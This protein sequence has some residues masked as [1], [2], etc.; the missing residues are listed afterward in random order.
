MTKAKD[1]RSHSMKEQA[2]LFKT[3]GF[4][5]LSALRSLFAKQDSKPRLTRWIL[6]LQEFDIEIRDKKGVKNLTADHLSQLE[7]P[8]LGKLTRAEIRDLFSKEQLML[9][10]NKKK[11]PWYANFANYLASKVLPFR[12]TRQEK[13]KFFSDLKHYFWDEPFLFKQYTNQI[14]QRCVSGNEASQTLRH[15]H[16]GPSGGTIGVQP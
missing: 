9:I 13:Q 14:I 12:S 1:Q 3:I 15:C 11:K 16:S 5:N 2:L 4:T 8:D 6:L 7:S 10:F